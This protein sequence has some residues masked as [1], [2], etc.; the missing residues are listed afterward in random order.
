MFN[1][2][3][4]ISFTL[5]WVALI[6]HSLKFLLGKGSSFF[7]MTSMCQFSVAL[8]WK[9]LWRYSKNDTPKC[10]L[11]YVLVHGI[12]ANLQF[13]NLL[14]KM[15]ETD[16]SSF[17]NHIITNFMICTPISL[18]SLGFTGLMCV[19]CA[20][21]CFGQNV[22]MCYNPYPQIEEQLTEQGCFA[23][24][25]ERFYRQINVVAHVFFAHYVMRLLAI[26]LYI[27]R[28]MMRQQGG[29]LK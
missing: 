1:S 27:E 4:V 8:L 16:K 14:G 7:I 28:E 21:L 2:V 29:Q 24:G 23:F 12:C 13:W 19:F 22:A 9:L 18:N 25:Y 3:F 26:G 15:N 11:L 20:L 17:E 10:L 5:M 6:S